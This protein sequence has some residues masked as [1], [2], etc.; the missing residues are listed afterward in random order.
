MVI[1]LNGIGHSL[2]E[3]AA[4]V[5]KG[6][7]DIRQKTLDFRLKKRKLIK[8]SLSTAQFFRFDALNDKSLLNIIRKVIISP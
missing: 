3:Y 4:K 2:E 1:W 6:T 7:F 5:R 8:R